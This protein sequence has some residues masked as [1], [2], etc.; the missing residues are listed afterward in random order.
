MTAFEPIFPEDGE[1][2]PCGSQL[3]AGAAGGDASA[4]PDQSAHLLR[5][6]EKG[7]VRPLG[8][9][10]FHFHQL[11]YQTTRVFW[12]FRLRRTFCPLILGAGDR[13]AASRS[14]AQQRTRALPIRI[15]PH[16]CPCA[17][18]VGKGGRRAPPRGLSKAAADSPTSSF[19][20]VV[21]RMATITS[22]EVNFLVYRYLQESGEPRAA[23]LPEG[24]R[25][26]VWRK[27]GIPCVG[28]AHGFSAAALFPRVGL[29]LSIAGPLLH[30]GLALG[31]R[32]PH[33]ALLDP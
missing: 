10:L 22:E 26:Q 25:G 19:L 33:R 5:C 16:P 8:F 29:R 7:R 14:R 21:G 28:G 17:R 31:A 4:R 30:A 1:E 12:A 24:W 23:P 18:L 9:S 2:G 3:R 15:G 20:V 13:H 32:T 6:V 11:R 27:R